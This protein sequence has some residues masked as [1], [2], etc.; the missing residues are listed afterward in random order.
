MQKSPETEARPTEAEIAETIGVLE[1]DL[2]PES[3]AAPRRE[4]NQRRWLK[5][6][7][8]PGMLW[9]IMGVIFPAGVVAFEA[10]TG[11]CAGALFDPMPTIWH[12][13]IAA[14]VP[15]SN[16]LVWM[17]IHKDWHEHRR[18]IAWMNGAAI[19]IAAFYTLIFLPLLPLAA[20]ALVMF[21]LGTLPMTPLFSL[22]A[23]IQGRRY[24][25][26]SQTL[27]RTGTG[28]ATAQTA[29]TAQLPLWPGLLF[30]I[31][32][33]I[34]AEL[35]GLS[36][37]TG[38]QMALSSDP[39]TSA[40]GVRLLQTLGSNDLLLRR[41]YG[42]PGKTDLLSVLFDE[43]VSPEQ[44][45]KVYYRVTGEPFS[46]APRPRMTSRLW[47]FDEPFDTDRGGS[48]VG[49]QVEALSLSSSRMDQSVDADAGVGYLEWT[50]IFKNNAAFPEEA[51]TEIAL[52]EQSVISRVTLWINGEE[53]EAAFGG[54]SQTRQA[55]ENVVRQRRD[56]LLVTTSGDGRALVECFPV[57]AYGEMKVR[58]GI[59]APLQL[60]NLEEAYVR[61]PYLADHNFKLDDNA[62]HAVWIEGRQPITTA[63][64]ALK[65]ESVGQGVFALR[66]DV[67]DSE[68]TGKATAI[69]VRRSGNAT[70]SWGAD[71]GSKNEGVI[72]Q[73]IEEQ[74]IAAPSR[75]VLVIDGSAVMGGAR[76]EIAASLAR[77]PANVKAEILVAGDGSTELG[78][79]NGPDNSTL[80]QRLRNIDF[81]GGR[82]N[83]PALVR[84]W[85]IAAAEPGA[86]I[87][88]V[89]GSQQVVLHP[90]EDLR[91]R[92]ERRPHGP[93]LY[94][95]SVRNSGDVITAGL[96]GVDAVRTL[97]AAGSVGETLE[98]LFKSWDGHST[99]FVYVRER[100]RPTHASTNSHASALPSHLARLWAHDEALRL[101]A[102]GPQQRDEAIKLAAAYQ[103]VTPV[104]GAVVLESAQQY[105]DAGLEP[106][107]PDQVPTVPEPEEWALIIIVG[108][109][110]A[111]VMFRGRL[112]WNV[113]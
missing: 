75:V 100:A 31:A 71:P 20:V 58:I 95:L 7:A 17:A 88:W 81:A 54:R 32:V 76:D 93:R 13:F 68:L 12:V 106:A 38:L 5:P 36:T 112:R 86:A 64:G 26:K 56:P 85:D 59:T 92:W 41:C 3:A 21:G 47:L 33:L 29:Q 27:T 48:T 49:G 39:A 45:R 70:T 63:N 35:P 52:P 107:S 105:R 77:L 104:T 1:Q 19:G 73:R 57:P 9:L 99:E 65:A 110:L 53:Q 109:T 16:L 83:V 61:L 2:R 34:G 30:A 80:V 11:F 22:I 111:W 69:R 8:T 66:G 23:A 102:S 42:A 113:C 84:A 62:V 60:E 6:R 82:D 94:A 25:Q 98:Q 96:D 87:V 28:Q 24:L 51:R 89:H 50:M 67:R 74:P 4:S 18:R 14:S 43:Q 10:I 15:A 91:Q 40:R 55:Y 97:R 103:I 46:N 108:I 44:A 79:T 37:H 101:I 78:H 72:V 90:I